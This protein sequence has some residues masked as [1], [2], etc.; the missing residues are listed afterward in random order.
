MCVC[1]NS[2]KAKIKFE[3]TKIKFKIC[4]GV[5]IQIVVVQIDVGIDRID[6]DGW[7]EF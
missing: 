2:G 4:Q 3:T 5:W 1:P 6:F 7:S